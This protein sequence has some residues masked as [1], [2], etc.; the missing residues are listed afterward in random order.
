MDYK[1]LI[2]IIAIFCLVIIIANLL[3]YS[4]RVISGIVF[5]IV[6]III[7]IIAFPG[8]KWMK[9]ISEKTT[10]H[11]STSNSRMSKRDKE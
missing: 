5:W 10:G 9:K 1:T 6:I 2:K 8:M 11:E 7:A 4:F 3:L